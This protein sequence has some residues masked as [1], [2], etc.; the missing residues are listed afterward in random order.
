[1][2]LLIMEFSQPPITSSLFGPNNLLSTRFSNS[3]NVRDKVSHPYKTTGKVIVLYILIVMF[4][5]RRQEVRR[6]WAEWK[7]ALPEFNLLLIY[8]RI[9]L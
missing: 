1:M 9:I 4:F 7:Q 8:S 5:D 6:F 3:L 2:K